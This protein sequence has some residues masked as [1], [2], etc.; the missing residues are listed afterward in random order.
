M[1][2]CLILRKQFT[3]CMTKDK[4]KCVFPFLDGDSQHDKCEW[5]DKKFE[6]ATEVN[7]DNKPASVGDCLYQCELKGS[8][9]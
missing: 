4:K 9:Y 5:K 6:C 3:E 2:L 8:I 7:K 1:I